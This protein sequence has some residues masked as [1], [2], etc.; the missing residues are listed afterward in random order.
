VTA[1]G[2]GREREAGTLPDRRRTPLEGWRGGSVL[3]V[4]AFAAMAG[5]GQLLAFAVWAVA[6]SGASLGAF[7]RIGA[8]YLGA[9]NH[10]AIEVELPRTSVTATDIGAASLSIGVALLSVTAVAIWLLV[11]A[12]RALADRGGGGTGHRMLLGMWVAPSY[13]AST[14]AVGALVDVRT[15]LRSAGFGVGEVHVSLSAW[16]ALAFPAAIAIVAGAAG[17]LRSALAAR[18]PDDPAMARVEAAVSGGWR[19]FV[20]GV[21]LSL[22]GLFVAGIVQPDGPA[23]LLTPTTARYLRGVFDRPVEGLVLLAHHLALAP[24]EAVWTLVPAMGACDGVH[25]DASENVLCYGRFPLDVTT[26][27]EPLTG[28]E[29][30]PVPFGEIR[31]GAAPLGYL[32]FL[33]VPGVASVLGGRRAA[34]RLG[35]G[36]R[37]SL[38]AGAS[39]GL[40]FAALVA[41]A[42]LLSSVT[43]G[44]GGAGRAGWVIAG[45]D[46]AAGTLL[47]AVWGIVGG[48]VGGAT[49]GWSARIRWASRTARPARAGT[50]A[51]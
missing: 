39:A 49:A 11:R 22:A 45:P 44:Y 18:T 24:D 48:S 36:L 50:P 8:V 4:L 17:G 15:T 25:G 31:F 29:V 5:I 28:D 16:Q 35:A 21:A 23:A 30:V 41:A 51:R 42:S 27:P 14:F 34:E 19:M 37:A 13:A 7:A 43:V 38:L 32:L 10:V 9:F 2:P 47:A 33:L 6:G 26:T 3:G 12:G 20:A 40:V 46:V 1:G